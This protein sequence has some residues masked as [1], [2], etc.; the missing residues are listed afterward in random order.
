M[1]Y[2]R[3]ASMILK[4]EMKISKIDKEIFSTSIIGYVAYLIDWMPYSITLLLLDLFLNKSSL[5]DDFGFG[6][7]FKMN[8]DLR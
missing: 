4:R 7:N 5:I 8:F 2:M 1:G 3:R 6:I